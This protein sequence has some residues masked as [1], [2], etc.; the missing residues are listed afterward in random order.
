MATS[1]LLVFGL[2]ADAQRLISL[3]FQRGR[4][5]K[6]YEALLRGEPRAE[7]GR[8]ALPLIADWPN[9]PLQMVDHERGKR[10]ETLWRVLERTSW[11]HQRATR[12]EMTPITGKTHQLRVHAMTPCK[13]GGIGCPIIGDALYDSLFPAERLMLHARSLEFTDPETLRR[14]R[15][16]SIVPF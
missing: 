13:D 16:E 8:V 11:Q 3:Q 4:V 5:A 6:R 9:R 12:V 2:D 14:V 7:R 15:V 10:A 1:G